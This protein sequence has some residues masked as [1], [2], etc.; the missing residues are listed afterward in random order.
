[1]MCSFLGVL[2]SGDNVF[3]LRLD[4]LYFVE[5]GLVFI[6]QSAKTR[7]I[8]DICTEDDVGTCTSS[9]KQQSTGV[10]LEYIPKLNTVHI[11]SQP[12]LFIS[13]NIK[14]K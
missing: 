9:S 4:S 1:M 14:Y 11:S 8:Y 12:K 3:S 6:V 7:P 10:K 13:Y 5:V 2:K